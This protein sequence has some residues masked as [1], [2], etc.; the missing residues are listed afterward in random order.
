[1]ASITVNTMMATTASIIPTMTILP[2]IIIRGGITEP[3]A[4]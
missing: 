2:G 1:M 4:R 3:S